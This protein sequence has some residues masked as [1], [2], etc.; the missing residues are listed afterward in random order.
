VLTWAELE[1][2]APEIAAL[3]RALIERFQFVLVGTLT[4]DGSP[5]VTPVE[6]YIIDGHLL[7]NMIPGS[8]KARDLLRDPR[9]YV[10]APVTAKEGSPEFK[11]AGRADVLEDEALRTKLDDLFWEMIQWRPAPESHYFEFL[12]ERA[13][14]VSYRDSTQR[15]IRW[16]LGQPEKHL[17][18]PDT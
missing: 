9:V 8:L 10:H 11:L 6:A 7:A 14:W 4:K 13:A 3:G 17:E 1:Q 5:R 12:A 18:K 2:E 16:R 15:S